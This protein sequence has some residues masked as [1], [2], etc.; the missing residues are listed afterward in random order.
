M[1]GSSAKASAR[2]E[3]AEEGVEGDDGP[4][5]SEG[6][7]AGVG[8]REWT[9]EFGLEVA[10]LPGWF[11]ENQR[12]MGRVGWLARLRFWAAE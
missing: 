12:R 11:A 7:A 4:G 1:C 2:T 9:G 3:R 6:F 8:G 10:D 5:E